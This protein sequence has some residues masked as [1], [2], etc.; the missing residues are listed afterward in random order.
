LAVIKPKPDEVYCGGKLEAVETEEGEA[1]AGHH[2]LEHMKLDQALDAE[3]SGDHGRAGEET[4]VDGCKAFC[5][6]I[7]RSARKS[8]APSHFAPSAS[9]SKRASTPRNPATA[10]TTGQAGKKSSPSTKVDKPSRHWYHATIGLLEEEGRAF[11]AF[12]GAGDDVLSPIVKSLLRE[13]VRRMYRAAFPCKPAPT[14]LDIDHPTTRQEVFDMMAFCAP[15]YNCTFKPE[16]LIEAFDAKSGA[17]RDLLRSRNLLD[18]YI[19]TTTGT[20]HWS[21]TLF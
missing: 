3:A 21:L 7:R 20:C 16:K 12:T 13:A 15:H 4:S 10:R 14:T 18:L 1:E 6:T 5:T 19:T 11:A 8:K 17:I 9:D 2:S